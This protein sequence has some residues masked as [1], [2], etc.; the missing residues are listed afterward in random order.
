MKTIKIFLVG[1]VLFL[2]L[3]VRAQ[4]SVSVQIGT[5]PAWGPAGYDRERYYYLP[6]VESYYDVQTSMFIYHSGFSWVQRP[7]LPNRYR[8]YDLY[9]GYKVVMVDYHGVRPYEHFREHRMRYARG[10]RGVEQRNIGSRYNDDHD[11]VEH[12]NRGR[13]ERGRGDDHGNNGHGHGRGRNR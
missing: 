9:H 11:R 4:V 8:N 3:I 5:P 7:Y 13:E 1:V 2:G 12:D 6:D 10:Y